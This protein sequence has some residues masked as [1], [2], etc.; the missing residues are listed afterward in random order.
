M[1]LLPA[2]SHSPTAT[3]SATVTSSK[4]SPSLPPPSSCSPSRSPTSFYSGYRTWPRRQHGR[5][6][7]G[8]LLGPLLGSARDGAFGDSRRCS[9]SRGWVELAW[10]RQL[11]RH[12]ISQALSPDIGSSSARDQELEREYGCSG[13]LLHVLQE[14]VAAERRREM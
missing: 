9:G 11:A 7:T 4:R 6:G 14:L 1:V 5:G 8:V 12:R 2:C 3:L 10:H 13:E